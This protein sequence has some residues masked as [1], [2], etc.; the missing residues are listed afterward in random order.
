[1]NTY[2]GDEDVLYEDFFDVGSKLTLLCDLRKKL[3]MWVVLT[4]T[5]YRRY[6]NL[7]RKLSEV[8]QTVPTSIVCCTD[9]TA[10]FRMLYRQ[11]RQVSHVVQIPP[12]FVCYRYSTAKYR[13]L[14]RQYRQVSYVVA[15]IFAPSI[16]C[17]TDSTAKFRM[18][19][20]QHRKVFFC[21][22]DSIVKYRMLYRQ[23]RQVSYV[24][25]KVPPSIVCC[26][27]S[28]VKFRMLYRQYR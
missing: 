14:Y 7:H 12:N 25:Q 27:N 18:L 23:Y 24:A 5:L 10:K 2:V 20:R 22:T 4:L 21:C 9:S 19:Y 13:M 17:C 26:T 16:V 1:M 3:R 6:R 11:Y 15:D 8:V 28:T